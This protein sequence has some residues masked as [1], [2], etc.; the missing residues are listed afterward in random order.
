MW[1][2]LLCRVLLFERSQQQSFATFNNL[3]LVLLKILIFQ[4][5]CTVNI[6]T[7]CTEYEPYRIK[8]LGFRLFNFPYIIYV[9][10]KLIMLILSV[11]ITST[12]SLKVYCIRVICQILKGVFLK[13][14]Y[15]LV[16]INNYMWVYIHL[17][18]YKVVNPAF[19]IILVSDPGS[20]RLT[21]GLWGDFQLVRGLT[22]WWLVS[23]LAYKD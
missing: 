22:Y 19:F 1:K 13:G 11:I 10:I 6:S 16:G 20:Y 5:H 23:S 3:L 12:N 18:L 8:G 15:A 2:V 7:F 21:V 9:V 14:G 17:H 4:G